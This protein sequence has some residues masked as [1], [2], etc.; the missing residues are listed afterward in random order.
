MKKNKNN[1]LR[2]CGTRSTNTSSNKK[3]NN[4]KS[5]KSNDK[6]IGFEN[7]TRS[8]ELEHD[9]SKSFELE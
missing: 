2:N 7:E 8:F 6:N 3:S 9:S 1:N 5:N 4:H